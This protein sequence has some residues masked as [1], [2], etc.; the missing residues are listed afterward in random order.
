MRSVVISLILFIILI[1]GTV[2]NAYFINNGVV[3]LSASLSD[4][5][6]IHASD[7]LE[8]IIEFDDQ[9]HE[10]MN[11]A[12]LTSTYSELSK[13]SCYIDELY[14]HLQN[15]NTVDFENTKCMLKNT[16]KELPRTEKLS[17]ESIF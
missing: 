17:F 13:I 16:L 3:E 11:I 2:S 14:V 1:T 15:K 10:F 8:R 12:A 9:W 6:E 7:C 5:P 4:I